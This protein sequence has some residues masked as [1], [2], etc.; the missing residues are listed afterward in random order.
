MPVNLI[1]IKAQIERTRRA[2][3]A[4]GLKPSPEGKSYPRLFGGWLREIDGKVLTEKS[5]EQQKPSQR[6]RGY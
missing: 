5:K 6:E 4:R 1:L 2:E 3:I